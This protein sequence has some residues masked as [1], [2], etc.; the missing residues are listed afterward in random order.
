MKKVLR[1]GV[2]LAVMF[3]LVTG[4]INGRAAEVKAENRSF[5]EQFFDA[6]WYFFK[7]HNEN[8]EIAGMRG[9]AKALADHYYT[10]GI[11]LGYSPSVAFDP[12]EF[13]EL[14]PDLK[15]VY[16]ND[17]A[18]VHDH[19]IILI[20]FGD[21]NRK[22][23]RFF[24]KAYYATV[25][26][27]DWLNATNY[28]L[29]E[30]FCQYGVYEGRL[31][32]NTNEA[33]SLMWMF[34]FL[35]YGYYNAD[36]KRLYVNDP[37]D[38]RRNLFGHFLLYNIL[39][40]E[41]RRSTDHFNIGYY[42]D[43]IGK[44][45]EDAFWYYVRT[46][47]KDGDE[48]IPVYSI[49]Y[50]A[51]GGSGAPPAQKKTE[52][53]DLKLSSV[54]P[55]RTGYDFMGWGTSRDAGTVAYT[56]GSTYK[57]NASVQ[58][59]A[60]WRAKTYTITY[61]VNGG[62]SSI[63]IPDQVK[64]HGK[65]LTLSAVEPV[66]VNYGFLGWATSRDAE[67][68]LYRPG[69]VY[70]AEGNATLY[71]VWKKLV[72]QV[73][74]DANAEGDEASVTGMPESFERE[75]GEEITIS[76][77]IPSR[78][79]YTFQGWGRI[80]EG[81]L[82]KEY[83]AGERFNENIS[84][85]LYASWKINKY[86]VTYYYADENGDYI[87][88]RTQEKTYGANLVLVETAPSKAGYDFKGWALSPSVSSVKYQPGDVYAENRKLD[89]YAVWE[90]KR[91]TVSYDANGGTGAPSD[92]VKKHGEPLKLAIS[93]PVCRGYTFL[94]W[95]T[96]SGDT[97]AEYESGQEYT[98][99]ANL[100]LYAVW[101][102][103]TYTVSYDANGGYFLDAPAKQTKEWGIAL[104]LTDQIPLKP[105]YDFL[106]W[107]AKKDAAFA[108]YQAEG[109]Y[110]ENENAVLYAVWK[111]GECTITYDANGGTGAPSPQ[112]KA[113]N[114]AVKLSAFVPVRTGYD[115]VGWGRTPEDNGAAYLPEDLY[116][117]NTSVVLYAV[118]KVKS[119][120]VSY[121]ANGGVF[122]GSI[123]DDVKYYG[124][125]LKLTEQRPVRDGYNFLGWSELDS[126]KT[127][128]YEAGGLF[129]QNRDVVL[130]AVWEKKKTGEDDGAGGNNG[131]G[132]GNH[133]GQ[134]NP[135]QTGGES[136]EPE[137]SI[138]T[139]KS[140]YKVVYGTKPFSLNVRA[141]EKITLSYQS[142][143]TKVAKVSGEGTV[144]VK[145]CGVAKITITASAGSQTVKKT[146]SVQVVP[147]K[148]NAKV[149]Y[150]KGQR[151]LRVEWNKDGKA[152]G[153]VVC[154]S[155]SKKFSKKDTREYPYGKSVS[156]RI[157]SGLKK[158]TYYIRVRSY[159][160]A[161]KK[162]YY[163]GWSSTKKVKIS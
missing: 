114:E 79:G 152:A 46:G 21:E 157:Y 95:S 34:N 7:H 99:D 103:I 62:D 144:T 37:D 85:I 42:A 129:T 31:G 76:S 107:S 73:V 91:Y 146:V 51:N 2:F 120:T 58:L 74:Y 159:V 16:K 61:H 101:R 149:K 1:T 88:W 40:G 145:G 125:A 53:I 138:R 163:G 148:Q 71:A 135:G 72:Y 116:M 156:G 108:S 35:S 36:V 111:V 123:R 130:Y 78:E 11:A 151:K 6:N 131:G 65:E 19:F 98:K 87:A 8:A 133:T 20:L 12:K 59:F 17:M 70:R 162:K 110:T 39:D 25:M 113:Y 139:E 13:L 115:F 28:Q 117:E 153:Y 155:K 105:G 45:C 15:P 112:K 119:Y 9:N 150:N 147:K 29:Y 104:K 57:A 23:S 14:N 38:G 22:T 161:G 60:I 55:T 97:E 48:T 63:R 127:A 64:T 80:M 102:K 81:G 106:G 158:G 128:S 68:A 52:S 26:G 66:R 94:G 154:I 24:D 4:G 82:I 18:K 134:E 77:A 32:A 124:T 67:T 118:W 30:H 142:D 50:D 96:R 132:N 5:P 93:V 100:K 43:R 27:D 69:A 41:G 44:S 143:N 140:D 89:L 160:K 109:E 49:T 33:K 90:L 75:A 92:Q 10:K 122:A 141:G 47:Y 86:P 137:V 126:A 121:D 56:P 54:K 3:L 84:L 83:K 136:L